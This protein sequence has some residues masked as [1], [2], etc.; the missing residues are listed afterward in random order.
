MTHPMPTPRSELRGDPGG[1]RLRGAPGVSGGEIRHLY[2]TRLLNAAVRQR[3]A[4]KERDREYPLDR[5]N[6]MRA[7]INYSPYYLRELAGCWDDIEATVVCRMHMSGTRLL[8]IHM[9]AAIGLAVSERLGWR[10]PAQCFDVSRRLGEH[11]AARMLTYPSCDEVTPDS[12]VQPVPVQDAE[13]SALALLIQWKL[14]ELADRL[15]M[16]EH[17][18]HCLAPVASHGG[19][20]PVLRRG[21][22]YQRQHP[23]FP[24]RILIGVCLAPGFHVPQVVPFRG[25]LDGVIPASARRHWEVFV[26]RR[27]LSST[28]ELSELER[29][30]SAAMGHATAAERGERSRRV[31]EVRKMAIYST[32]ICEARAARGGRWRMPRDAYSA[33]WNNEVCERLG[34][35]ATTGGYAAGLLELTMAGLRMCE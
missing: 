15:A 31:L 13:A 25:V 19:H 16:G 1:S 7:L 18:L 30:L 10:L 26:D 33:I 20:V 9:A 6:D 23:A 28:S 17:P 27:A 35:G 12:E 4:A 14:A 5:L 24:H 34:I 11:L 21:F 3:I 22:F 29:Q 8:R 2:E 32:E